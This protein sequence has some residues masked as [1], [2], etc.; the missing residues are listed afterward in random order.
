MNYSL[1]KTPEARARLS[2]DFLARAVQDFSKIQSH[3]DWDLS[4]IQILRRVPTEKHY[5][6][7]KQ[8]RYAF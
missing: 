5:L 2:K 3:D 7:L 6:S 4:S 1:I 8:N